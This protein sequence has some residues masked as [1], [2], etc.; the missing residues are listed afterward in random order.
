MIGSGISNCKRRRREYVCMYVWTFTIHIS[1][2]TIIIVIVL[3][4]RTLIACSTGIITRLF[5][6]YC[7]ALC[8]VAVMVVVLWW[9]CGGGDGATVVGMVLWWRWWCSGGGDGVGVV[10]MVLLLI[11]FSLS[12][13]SC[14]Y[15]IKNVKI[16]KTES[17]PSSLVFR[18]SYSSILWRWNQTE[19]RCDKGK[20]AIVFISKVQRKTW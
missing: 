15:W 9:W 18:T 14:L 20:H 6:F 16:S 17:L 3:Y 5:Y 11:L 4:S 13:L 1:I 2:I 10:M 7:Y 8:S 12:S 19:R